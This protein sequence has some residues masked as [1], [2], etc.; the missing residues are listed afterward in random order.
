MLTEQNPLLAR[1][2]YW[3]K[4]EDAE[5]VPINVYLWFGERMPNGDYKCFVKIDKVCDRP[6]HSYGVDA[7][8]AL[9]LGMKFADTMLTTISALVT[10]SDG[11]PYRPT[12]WSPLFKTP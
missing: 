9:Q 12:G 4:D 3:Q 8:Q 7:M 11:T 1:S 2:L 10:F 6:K 5:R